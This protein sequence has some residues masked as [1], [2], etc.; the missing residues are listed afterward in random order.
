MTVDQTRRLSSYLAGRYVETRVRYCGDDRFLPFVAYR[1][2]STRIIEQSFIVEQERP[3][4]ISNDLERRHSVTDT[5]DCKKH[6][7]FRVDNWRATK[8][9]SLSGRADLSDQQ[10]RA[11]HVKI[12][13]GSPL[14]ASGNC[15]GIPHLVW[16]G[17][18][19]RRFNFWQTVDPRSRDPSR[20]QRLRCN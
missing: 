4:C 7:L 12:T 17:A 10:N 18:H 9:R 11:M 6:Q 19:Y 8:T 5:A 15:R 1:D 16:A 2:T 14:G 20:N 13:E 3:S